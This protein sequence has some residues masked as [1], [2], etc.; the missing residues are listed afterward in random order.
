SGRSLI[1]CSGSVKSAKA[2]R[3][4]QSGSTVESRNPSLTSRL[5]TQDEAPWVLFRLL[6]GA[7]GLSLGHMIAGFDLCR[8]LV[9]QRFMHAGGIPPM[10]PVH[11]FEFNLGS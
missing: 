8:G 11:G 5:K 2:R 10:D 4:P 7:Q 9:V 1:G 6:Y 3:T